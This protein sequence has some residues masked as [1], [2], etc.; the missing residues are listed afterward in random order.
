MVGEQAKAESQADAQ[1]A[2][3]ER[4]KARSPTAWAEI[5]D[6]S[7]A[8][9]YRY[10]Y[11]RTSDAGTAADLACKTFLEALEGI[12]RY[13][14]RGRP[15]LAWLYRIARNLVSDHLRAAQRESAALQRAA[16]V[17]QPHDPG[18]AASV[19]DW[20]DLQ[21]AL[22]RLTDDQQQLIALRYYSGYSTAEIAAAM[23][24]SE[25]AVYSLEVRAL[26]ALRRFMAPDSIVAAPGQAD[27]ISPPPQIDVVE[28]P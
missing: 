3:V 16:S 15:I 5:Y 6:L 27:K 22:S 20:Q 19:D 13:V 23:G 28:D 26:A 18:P 14:Y 11:A 7:Y 9:L 12:D 25:R 1:A 2:L 4:A 10:C 17:L 21:A 8:K 24:R